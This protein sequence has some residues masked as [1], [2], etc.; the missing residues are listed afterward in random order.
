MSFVKTVLM[1]Y[2]G[3]DPELAYNKEGKAFCHFSVAVAKYHKDKEG[4]KAPESMWYNA[5]CVGNNAD[6]AMNYLKKGYS[7]YLEGIPSTHLFNSS[8]GVEISND[9]FVTQLNLLPNQKAKLNSNAEDPED[10]NPE[11][12]EEDNEEEVVSVAAPKT[13]AKTR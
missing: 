1:G 2:L 13:K 12:Y 5:T 10:F 6:T 3:R 4:K 8:K 9:L 11:E 7:V